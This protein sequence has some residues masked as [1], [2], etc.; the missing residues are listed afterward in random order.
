MLFFVKYDNRDKR[1][2]VYQKK[3]IIESI[4]EY[5]RI[6]LYIPQ[7]K[8]TSISTIIT[9]VKSETNLITIDFNLIAKGMFEIEQFLA[10][11]YFGPRSFCKKLYG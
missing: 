1:K 8:I 4:K 9:I 3:E 6:F 7:M 5:R 10:T 11:C 2:Y